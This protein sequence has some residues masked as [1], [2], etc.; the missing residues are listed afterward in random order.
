[1]LETLASFL[2]VCGLF[3]ALCLWGIV[4]YYAM[5]LLDRGVGALGRFFVRWVVPPVLRMHLLLSGNFTA[6]LLYTMRDA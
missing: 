4:F 6:Y 3:M 1:M 2:A 5:R